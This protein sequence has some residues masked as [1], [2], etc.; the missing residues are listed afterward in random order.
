MRVTQAPG[1]DDDNVQPILDGVTE[2]FAPVNAVLSKFAT[3]CKGVRQGSVPDS[4]ATERAMRLKAE[5]EANKLRRVVALVL[6]RRNSYEV[7]ADDGSRRA[8]CDWCEK[9]ADRE[10]DIDHADDCPVTWMVNVLLDRP[11]AWDNAD[12]GDPGDEA[13]HG[14]VDTSWRG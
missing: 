11:N 2:A 5:A 3:V 8:N 9:E 12:D 7:H 6:D 13:P 1:Y 14:A 4:I 10:L